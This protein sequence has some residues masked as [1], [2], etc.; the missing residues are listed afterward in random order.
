MFGSIEEV[1][2]AADEAAGNEPQ[3][4]RPRP[5]PVDDRAF[6]AHVDKHA[7]TYVAR[8][9]EFVA[10]PGV[11]A[12]PQRRPDVTRAVEWVKSW[13]E[14]LGADS[15]SLEPLGDQT[16]SDG[17]V[18]PLPPALLASFGD[19][20]K[21]PWKPTLVVYGHLDVQPA[22]KSDG[23]DTEPFELTEVDGKLYGRGASDD[24][25]PVTAWRAGPRVEPGGA[26]VPLRAARA[27]PDA[28]PPRRAQCG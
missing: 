20:K 15:T 11:S 5:E 18:L 10:I 6:F 4:K 21:E 24:K 7:D 8:L 23:W 3:A 28:R 9:K 19:P 1:E 17:T 25:G 26:P 27:L 16:L 22:Y 2:G 13:L 14:R 12:E